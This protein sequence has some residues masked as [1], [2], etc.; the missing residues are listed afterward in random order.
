MRA[1][2]AAEGLPQGLKGEGDTVTCRACGLV[3]GGARCP[4]EAFALL[5][6]AR[7]KGT[8]EP[9]SQAAENAERRE[10]FPVRKKSFGLGF[11]GS[12]R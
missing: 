5:G 1:A 12:G 3:L 7:L 10:L 2:R 4:T 9:A 8:R 6:D 11:E